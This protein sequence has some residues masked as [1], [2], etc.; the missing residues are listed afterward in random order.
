MSA[1]KASGNELVLTLAQMIVVK[2]NTD[3]AR[4]IQNKIGLIYLIAMN[5][6]HECNRNSE[7]Q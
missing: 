2:S 4:I 5:A 3:L 7:Y 1:K 6:P